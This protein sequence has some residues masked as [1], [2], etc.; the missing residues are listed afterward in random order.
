METTLKHRQLSEMSISL[1]IDG[2]LLRGESELSVSEADDGKES[3]YRES[4]SEI[5]AGAQSLIDELELNVQVIG[6]TVDGLEPAA[7]V[8]PRMSLV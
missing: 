7:G 4:E 2:N 1:S 3:S 5:E 6:D 8:K